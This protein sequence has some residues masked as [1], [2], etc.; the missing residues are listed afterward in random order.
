VHRD[1]DLSSLF[2]GGLF[3]L[4]EKKNGILPARRERAILLAGR[5]HP[6]HIVDKRVHARRS[7]GLA[8]TA[9]WEDERGI[10][11]QLHCTTRDVSAGG[12]FAQ[13]T[14][15]PMPG[16]PIRFTMALPATVSGLPDVEIRAEGSVARV[17]RLATG[18]MAG[19][20]VQNSKFSIHT[21]IPAAPVRDRGLE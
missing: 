19:F 1:G 2:S 4:V 11:Q 6:A 12:I 8:L 20:A 10:E 15:A 21:V 3:V 14:T 18:G 13:A 7:L 17:E 9:S 5:W 16:T